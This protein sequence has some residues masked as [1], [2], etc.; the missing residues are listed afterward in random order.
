MI[1]ICVFLLFSEHVWQVHV[2]N[3]GLGTIG[4]IGLYRLCLTEE[5]LTLISVER[6]THPLVFIL[7]NIRSCGHLGCFIFIEVSF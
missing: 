5:T 6:D 4:L 3:R 1:L 7:S 2:V